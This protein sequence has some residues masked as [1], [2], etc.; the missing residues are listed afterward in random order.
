MKRILLFLLFLQCNLTFAQTYFNNYNPSGYSYEVIKVLYIK[1]TFYILSASNCFG[2]IG[3]NYLIKADKYGKKIQKFQFTDYPY[4]KVGRDIILDKD[5]NLVLIGTRGQSLDKN[6][7][8]IYKI[9]LNGDSINVKYFDD[10]N[11]DR[12]DADKIIQTRDS[13]YMIYAQRGVDYQ[14]A[15]QFL[16]KA[17]RKGNKLWE[18]RIDGDTLGKYT[19]YQYG[20]NLFELENGDFWMSYNI[21][22]YVLG[23]DEYAGIIRTDSLRE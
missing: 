8:M 3:C 1:D 5:S 18:K 9:N 13:N 17:D 19:I 23:Y 6:T 7:I 11:I 16:I 4:K 22:P 20:N 15:R 21:E 14:W 10:T 2:V 12:E